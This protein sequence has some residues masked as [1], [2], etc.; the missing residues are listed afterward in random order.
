LLAALALERSKV[1]SSLSMA[2]DFA[3]IL[4]VLGL[5]VPWRGTVK[6]R[7]LLAWPQLETRERLALYAS[8][9]VSQ[10]AATSN[11]LAGGA[12]GN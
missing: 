8:Q 9:G 12:I 3:L 7:R 6:V 2:W 1:V 10:R 5:F 4:L 11:E